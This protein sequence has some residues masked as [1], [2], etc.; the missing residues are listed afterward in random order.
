MPLNLHPHNLQTLDYHPVL[1][2]CPIP[3]SWTTD[4]IRLRLLSS[5]EKGPLR[6]PRPIPKFEGE[7]AIEGVRGSAAA[8]GAVA[9]GLEGDFLGVVGK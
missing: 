5:L 6:R 8:V 2:P 3:Q 7:E 1:K 4:S 9:G